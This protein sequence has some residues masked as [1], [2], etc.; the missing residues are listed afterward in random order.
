MRFESFYNVETKKQTGL[1][2]ARINRAY[3]NDFP[4]NVAA[5]CISVHVQTMK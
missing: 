1:I 4:Q 3:P 2:D 5:S